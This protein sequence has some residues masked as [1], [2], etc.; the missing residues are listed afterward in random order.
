MQGGIKNRNFRPI[1][2]FISEMMQVTAIVTM[3]GEYETVPR[4]Y[5][6]AIPMTLNDP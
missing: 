3:K 4:L 2:R 5:S 1:S 6:G